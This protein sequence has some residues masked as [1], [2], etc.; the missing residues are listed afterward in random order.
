M[1]RYGDESRVEAGKAFGAGHESMTAAG[2]IGVN[3]YGFD[4]AVCTASFQRLT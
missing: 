3:H 1:R 4:R 2:G